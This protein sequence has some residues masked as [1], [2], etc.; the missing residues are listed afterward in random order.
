MGSRPVRVGNAAFDNLQL[1]IYGELMDS[2]YLYYKYGSPMGDD[3]WTN[4]A[5][6]MDWLSA[7][8]HRP[9]EGLWEVRGGR[10]AVGFLR[11][12][13]WVGLGPALPLATQRSLPAPPP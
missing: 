2:V 9:D 3:A 11:M 5:R 8:W 10:Q 7:N 13:G 4:L 1:D 6:L 12:M